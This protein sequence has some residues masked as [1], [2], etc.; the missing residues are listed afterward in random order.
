[1]TP[2]SNPQAAPYRVQPQQRLFASPQ[3]MAGRCGS[4]LVWRARGQ[5]QTDLAKMH[6][7]LP[8][9]WLPVAARIARSGAA[10]G[11]PWVSRAG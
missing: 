10:R 2:R 8:L 6:S 11:A 4:V 5:G 9:E 3:A 1:M 7:G